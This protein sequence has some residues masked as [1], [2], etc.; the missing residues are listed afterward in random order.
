[1][2]RLMK[3]FSIVIC[4]F[5]LS[6]CSSN[7]E[8]N[9]DVY[10]NEQGYNLEDEI[11]L[12]INLKT[13]D[14]N[15]VVCPMINIEK[16]GEDDIGRIAESLNFSTENVEF[17]NLHLSTFAEIYNDNYWTFETILFSEDDEF[18]LSNGDTIEKINLT[19]KEKGRYNI[20]LEEKTDSDECD[21]TYGDSLS[22]NISK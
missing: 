9:Y 18:D 17:L 13:D 15:I 20:T 11:T 4:L 6:A 1:M 5:C 2:K 16:E 7:K 19:L 14:Q 10:I 21:Y 22:L 8:D 12:E 3:I